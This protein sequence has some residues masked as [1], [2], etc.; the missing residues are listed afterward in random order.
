MEVDCDVI[1]SQNIRTT[2]GYV[3]V[4]FEDASISTFRAFSTRSSCHCEVG[5]GS[6]G[7]NA[8]CSRSEVA[9]DVISSAD[10]DT[11]WCYA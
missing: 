7:M 5:D 11:F 6:S 10:V 2:L 8:I 4:N 1:S 9:D 3:V